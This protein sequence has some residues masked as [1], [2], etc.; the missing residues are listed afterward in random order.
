MSLDI[1]EQYK[2]AEGLAEGDLHQTTSH[3][4]ILIPQ[5]SDDP[6]DPLNWSRNKKLLTLGVVSFASCISLAQLLANQ[7]GFLPQ[8]ELYHVPPVNISYSVSH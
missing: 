8:A 7:A 3:G 1:K 6:R 5:P 2:H 4:V